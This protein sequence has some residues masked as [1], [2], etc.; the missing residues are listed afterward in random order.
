MNLQSVLNL[1]SLTTASLI[2]AIGVVLLTGI[3]LPAQIPENYRYTLGAVM[4]LYAGYRIWVLRL[5]QK[6]HDESVDE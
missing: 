3:F 6:R 1:L 5:K 4:T 2:L